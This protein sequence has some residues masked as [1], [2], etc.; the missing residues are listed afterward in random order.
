VAT[1]RNRTAKVEGIKQRR[2]QDAI[3]STQ[4]LPVEQWDLARYA[5]VA[6][7]LNQDLRTL[8][9]Y[10]RRFLKHRRVKKHSFLT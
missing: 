3:R 2:G 6:L 10:Q 9:E 4:M 8:R 7:M 1:H 5:S